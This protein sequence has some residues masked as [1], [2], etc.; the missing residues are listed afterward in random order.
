MEFNLDTTIDELHERGYISVRTTNC[1]QYADMYTLEDVINNIKTPSDLMNLRNFGRKSFKEIEPILNQLIPKHSTPKIENKE[2]LFSS[3]GEQLVDIITKSYSIALSGETAIKV[4]LREEYPHAYDLHFSIKDGL[5]KMLTVVELF[6]REENIEIRHTYKHYID[7]VMKGM[8]DAHIAEQKIYIDYKRISLNLAMR[9]ED[10]S[11]EEIVKYFLSPDAKD[12]L[13]EIY[14]DWANN[15]L[16]ERAKKFL[17]SYIPGYYDLI[18]YA[19]EPLSSYR[20]ICPGKTMKKT[21]NEI[22]QFNQKFKKEYYRISKLNDNEIYFEKL[23]REYPYLV[24]KQRVFVSSFTKEHNHAPLFFL[25]YHYLRISEDRSN[26]IYS[27][28]HGLFDKKERTLTEIAEAMN[29]TRE[30]VRQIANG[31]LEVQSSNIVKNEGWK[32]YKDLLD[33]PFIHEDTEEYKK[34]RDVE[35]L[36]INFN[37]FAYLVRIVVDFKIEDIEGHVIMINRKM[38]KLNFNNCMDTFYSI[39]NAKYSVDTYVPLRTVL[40]TTPREYRNEMTRLFKFIATDIYNIR[41]IDGNILYLP[42]NYIDVVEEVYEILAHN[43]EPMHVEDIFRAF[44]AKYPDHKFT[45]PVQIKP[46]LFRHKHIR[47]VGKS[48]CYAIDSWEG[49]YFGSIRDL[50]VDLLKDSDEPIHI[51]TL[52]EGVSEYYPNTTKSSVA[53]TMQDENMQRFIEFK[54]DYYGLTSKTY[55]DKYEPAPPIQRYTFEERFQMFKDFVETYHRFPGYNGSDHETTLMRWHYNVINGFMSITDEQKNRLEQ[56]LSNYD[57]L[58]YPRTA[59]E[60]EFLM[61]CND[62]KNYIQQ[63][64]TLPTNRQAPDLYY[65]FRR[66]RENYDSYTDKRRQYM[67]DLLNYILSFG[68]SI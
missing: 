62:L 24:S 33:L 32:H 59:I 17:K 13:Q 9:M 5:E 29:L 67:T 19:E 65:W 48:S 58:G 12:Y 63:H 14:E 40:K 60:S 16:G 52:Y 51:D 35:H 37:A 31:Y 53:A 54:G 64:H 41:I 23:K 43:G 27:L 34:I 42:Q 47:P 36:P 10:F 30:R 11:D 20:R 22:F 8:E 44:K 21:I 25:L 66:S 61:K 46:H 57:K 28:Y 15:E 18:K 39:I 3:L 6:S 1:L 49:V 45:E 38:W 7:L 2:D 55:S 56:E 50:L 4:Y 26:K 68:F